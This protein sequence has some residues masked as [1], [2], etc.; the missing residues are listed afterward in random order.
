MSQHVL[1]NASVLATAATAANAT[2]DSQFTFNSTDYAVF[3][4]ML[5]ISA[6]IGVYFGFFAK[7]EDTTEEYLMGGK[8]MKTIPIAISLVAS[9][10]S[11]ISI[12]TIPAELYAYGVNWFFNVVCMVV[13]VP[14]LNYVVIPVFYNNNITN[15]YEYLEL[16]FCREVRVVQTF[17]FI[18]TMFFMLPIFIFL[19]SL[20]FAQVTGYNVHFINTVVCSICIFYTMF[21]GIKAVVWTDVIQAAIMVVSV[22]LVGTM[23]AH[24]VGGFSEVF[25]I[26]GEGGR[27]D[28]NYNFDLTTR[29]TIWNIFTSATIIW[30]G[31]VGLNQSCVQ[32]IVSLPSL[33]H[34]RRCLVFFGLGFILIMFFNCFTGVVIYALFHDCDPIKAGHVSK[35]DKMVPYFVQD[36]VG[37][38]WGMPGVFIS[39]VFSAAL[40]TLSASIN[41]L[42]GVVYFDYIKPHIRHTEHRANVIMKLFVFFTG[43]YCIF[44]GI[45]VENFNSILQVVYSIT[46]VSYGSTCGVFL[47][48]MLVPK[49]HGR[50][51]LAGVFVSIACMATI[52]VLSWGRNHYDPL[53]TTTAG[54]PAPPLNGTTTESSTVSSLLLS[55][56]TEAP[57]KDGGFSILDL[58]FNLYTV[59]GFLITWLVGISVSCT[60]KPRAGYNLDPKLLSPVV[61]PFVDYKL[62]PMEEPH[63]LKLEKV[64]KV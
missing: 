55:S 48:G 40:S 14:L 5:S 2:P 62:T 49:S 27:L 64:E 22:V 29:S 37:H 15:C 23:G 6:S 47:L 60:V 41:S 51:A 3:A 24:R 32:R 42:G 8:R 1:S 25:R 39:C 21:G 18:T 36:T 56:T 9:Q 35:V 13:V 19:P 43:I 54:C 44:G 11:A 26:A 50:G 30:A 61:Q 17:I 58:S 57:V 33:G 7:G 52:V 28:I 34:A 20:A 45:L 59:A 46:G 31:Y 4:L 53:P 10:L 38:L 12:M 16:R 63:Q